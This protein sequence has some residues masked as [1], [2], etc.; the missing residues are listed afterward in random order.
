MSEQYYSS[1]SCVLGSGVL[2][3]TPSISWF[4]L[5]WVFVT[6]RRDIILP[7]YVFLKHYWYNSLLYLEVLF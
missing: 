4:C 3:V 2:V 6:P 1:N 7:N 5:R